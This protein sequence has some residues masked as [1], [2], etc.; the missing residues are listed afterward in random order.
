MDKEQK[1]LRNNQLLMSVLYGQHPFIRP[2]KSER[3]PI[4]K[5]VESQKILEAEAK[6]ER[7]KERNLKHLR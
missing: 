5:W 2:K 4:P 1:N 6:R 7:R 3:R